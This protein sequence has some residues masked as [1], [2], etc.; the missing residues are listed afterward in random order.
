MKRF[1]FRFNRVLETKRQL[2][3]MKKN[4]LA[5]LMAQRLRDEERLLAVQGELLDGQRELAGR[6][7][8]GE[9]LSRLVLIAS[10]FGKL[11]D[12]IR[13]FHD[14]L[15]GWDAQIEAKREELVEAGRETKTL[16]K[17]ED[18]DRRAHAKAAAGWEQKLIDDVATGRYVRELHRE[19][20]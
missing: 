15:A 10:Y 18:A 2:E 19:I 4:E 17:L 7:E 12:D 5:A 1:A 14:Q 3:D 11:A 9:T 6:A 13:R 8:A 16:E 20:Q